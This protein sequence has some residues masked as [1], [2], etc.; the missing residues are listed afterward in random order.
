[1]LRPTCCF[2]IGNVISWLLVLEFRK[3]FLFARYEHGIGGVTKDVE[4]AL[5]YSLLPVRKSYDAYHTVGA[6]PIV[7][8]DRLHENTVNEVRR[9]YL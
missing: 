1:M 2:P 6:Q 9:F 8:A 5:Q 4:T 7:E 3:P